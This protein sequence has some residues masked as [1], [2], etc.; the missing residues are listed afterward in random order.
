MALHQH[1]SKVE[2]AVVIFKFVMKAYILPRVTLEI[3]DFVADIGFFTIQNRDFTTLSRA[4]DIPE[5]SISTLYKLIFT[6]IKGEVSAM[7]LLKLFGIKSDIIERVSS[8]E[9]AKSNHLEDDKIIKFVSSL[10]MSNYLDERP[11]IDAEVFKDC[12]EMIIPIGMDVLSTAHTLGEVAINI[13]DDSDFDNI[14]DL[15]QTISRKVFESKDVIN[16]M[17]AELEQ[18][19]WNKNVD[20]SSIAKKRLKLFGSLT[21]MFDVLTG[22][23]STDNRFGN[24]K[25]A[26]LLA[27][28]IFSALKIDLKNPEKKLRSISTNESKMPLIKLKNN[29]TT[30]FGELDNLEQY[31]NVIINMFGTMISIS[32]CNHIEKSFE[33]NLQTDLGVHGK[34]LSEGLKNLL[35]EASCN[36]MDKQLDH[37]NAILQ[38]CARKGVSDADALSFAVLNDHNFDYNS[39]LGILQC[40]Y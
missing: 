28:N 6:K 19:S 34:L 36:T 1:T 20:I 3:A 35:Q 4:F 8:S 24:K 33:S 17:F 22:L 39:L 18:K 27:K 37:I 23:Y 14:A 31:K 5:R 30:K 11:D 15:I 32:R 13:R 25:T 10:L 7:D 40:P 29:L 21:E 16:E 2:K 9:M 12:C 38:V 26:T